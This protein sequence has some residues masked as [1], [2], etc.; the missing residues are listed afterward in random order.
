MEKITRGII[1]NKIK[2]WRR[3]LNIEKIWKI[4]FRI[5]NSALDMPTDHFDS[6]ACIQVDLK[7]F[8]AFIEFNLSELNEKNIDST[9]A[10]ELTHILLEPLTAFAGAG[11]GNKYKDITLQLCE[12]TVERLSLGL[13]ELYNELQVSKNKQLSTVK[14]KK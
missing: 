13:L 7:Y 14:S 11:A 1:S 9:I 10:H 12:S 8:Y 5:A 3:I 4:D 2:E 6:V